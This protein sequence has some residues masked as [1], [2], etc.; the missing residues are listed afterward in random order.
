M[1]S[2]TFS[3][4]YVTHYSE[5]GCATTVLQ[6]HLMHDGFHHHE[7]HPEPI[8]AAITGVHV[9]RKWWQETKST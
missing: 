9:D 8:H 3:R 2:D 1:S 6:P 7:T 4:Q 5:W